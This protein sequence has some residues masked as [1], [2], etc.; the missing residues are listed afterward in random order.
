MKKSAIIIDD[1]AR[2]IKSLEY[3]LLNFSDRID[4]VATS[5]DPIDG[6]QLIQSHKPDLVFLDIQMPKLSGFDLIKKFDPVPFKVI[7]TTAYDQFAIDAFRVNAIDYLL[8]PVNEEDL[9]NAINKFFNFT[10]QIEQTQI[11]SLLDHLN[12]QRNPSIV[13]FSTSEGVHFINKEDIIRIEASGNYSIVYTESH[14]SLLISKPLKKIEESLSEDFFFRLHQ[15]H[16][17]NVNYIKSYY[18]A[19][20]GSVELKD[21]T[22]IPVSRR[23]KDDLLKY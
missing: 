5:T 7:F 22:I 9:Q 13:T 12:K 18:K 15:S 4:L 20:A 3:E 14:K 16:L 23:K 1:E 17:V 11:K 19:K 10:S 8:K 21:G 2:S 6:I